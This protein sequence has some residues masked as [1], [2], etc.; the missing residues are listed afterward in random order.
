[1]A[2]DFGSHNQHDDIGE[3]LRDEKAML[4]DVRAQLRDVVLGAIDKMNKRGCYQSQWMCVHRIPP[5]PL[6]LVGWFVIPLGRYRARR[7][8]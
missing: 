3:I 6:W 8:R 5:V 4:N 1:V 7:R 2:A